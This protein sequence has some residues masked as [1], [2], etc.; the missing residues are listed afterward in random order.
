L[1][2]SAKMPRK[3]YVA[4][5]Q[6]AIEGVDVAG[7]SNIQRGGDDGEFTFDCVAHGGLL[8][9]SALIPGKSEQRVSYQNMRVSL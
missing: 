2:V 7:I 6:R 4:D 3:A 9:I 5:L 1:L 8:E